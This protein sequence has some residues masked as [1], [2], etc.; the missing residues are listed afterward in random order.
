MNT[1][2]SGLP[3]VMTFSGLDPTGG[4]GLLA[5]AEAILSMGGH[6][7]PVATA[8]LTGDT[9]ETKGCT[10]VAAI[11]V[12]GQARAVLEDMP[13]AAFKIG[14][15]ASLD[16]AEAI[17]AILLD[18]P[19]IPLVLDPV[20]WIPTDRPGGG[21]QLLDTLV[22]LL[23]PRA[24]VITV[25]TVETRRLAPEA[26]SPAAAAQQ[27]MSYGCGAVLISGTRTHS[28]AVTNH[29]Y[30]GRRL[31]K[32]FEWERLPGRY[33]GA[34]CTLASAI[35]TLLGHGLD[36]ASAAAEAQHY[37]WRALHHGFRLGHG[38]YLPNRLFWARHRGEQDA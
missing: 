34:G 9:V 24:A 36:A 30:A 31:I 25:N 12:V 29:L 4:G 17:H 33:H 15:I 37:T 18:Y 10:P 26:D 38:R 11:D 14:L 16:V 8:V 28:P 6:A 22:T 19:A 1:Q 35:A 23:L 32:S 7:L 27:L 3:P 2:R 21:D 20:C 13:V 5:D